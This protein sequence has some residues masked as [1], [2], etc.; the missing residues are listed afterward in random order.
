MEA[1]IGSREIMKYMSCRNEPC[2]LGHNMM[3]ELFCLNRVL[4]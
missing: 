3:K 4:L 2:Y 1:A